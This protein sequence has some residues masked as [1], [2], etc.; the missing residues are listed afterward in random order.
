MTKPSALSSKTLRARSPGKLNLTFDILGNLPDGYHEVETLMQ[1]VSIYDELIFTFQPAEK[2]SLTIEAIEYAENKADVPADQNNL[3]LKAAKVFQER[4]SQSAGVFEKN[5]QCQVRLTK[6]I[7]VAGGMGGG[8]GN[9]AA[10]LLVL[11]ECFDKIFSTDELKS[12]AAQLGA[13]VPFFIDGGTQIGSQ[14]G[15]VLQKIESAA[16]LSFLIVGPKL[17]GMSTPEVYRAYDEDK[18][19][20]HTRIS[21]HACAKAL[22]TDNQESIAQTLGNAFEPCVF[23][24]KP[25]LE[26]IATRLRSLGG[27][28]T[29]LTGSGPTLYVLTGNSQQSELIQARLNEEQS[30]RAN[31]WTNWPELQLNSWI[32]TSTDSGVELFSVE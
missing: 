20:R 11:N 9:A 10:T 21:A 30:A 27:Y 6:S 24:R 13:D 19:N 29:R 32:A 4:V 1:T 15:D 7:P 16:K 18:T 31:G 5:F 23:A 28:C 12:M 17:F 14:R 26:F 2:F 22:A 3:I 25:E 8:S